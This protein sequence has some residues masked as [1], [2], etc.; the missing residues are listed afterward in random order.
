[1]SEMND[2]HIALTDAKRAAE[3]L[4]S[5]VRSVDQRDWVRGAIGSIE[6]GIAAHERLSAQLR[7]GQKHVELPEDWKPTG[8]MCSWPTVSPPCSWC[9][10][11]E[12]HAE[13]E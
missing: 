4:G 13:D 6:R 10:D 8:C 12:N 1:M 2:I 5:W 11:P 9:T 7:N 3:A